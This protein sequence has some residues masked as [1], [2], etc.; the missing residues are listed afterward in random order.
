MNF[1][2]DIYAHKK[3]VDRQK[4]GESLSTINY[5]KLKDGIGILLNENASERLKIY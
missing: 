2:D 3:F 1:R 4:I 5:N